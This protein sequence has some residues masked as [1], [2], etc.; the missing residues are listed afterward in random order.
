M[1]YWYDRI[2]REARDNA[3][4]SLTWNGRKLRLV[5]GIYRA[6]TLAETPRQAQTRDAFAY[7]WNRRATY[8]SPRMGELGRQWLVAKYLD[9]DPQNL[10]RLVPRGAR[11]LDAGSGAGF[12][13]LNFLAPRLADIHYLG[14]DISTAVDVAAARFREHGLPGEFLQ[15]DIMDLPF[16]P[17]S[18]DLIFSEGVL[19]HTNDTAAALSRLARLLVPDGVILFYVYKVK[20][21]V[22]EFCDDHVRSWI[23]DLDHEAAWDAL[24]PL[25]RLGAALGALDVTIDVPEDVPMLGI[26]A[27]PV[28]VQRLFY[29]YVC[30]CF[31]DP[32]LTL[33][34]MNH[35]NFDWYRPAN[36]TRHTPEEVERFCAD[37]GLAIDRMV[38]DGSGI[39]VIARRLCRALSE[40]VS[41]L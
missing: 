36:C 34:E 9:G 26:P 40:Q 29:Y 15:F 16:A 25:T 19:H 14:A 31:Y 5:D 33:D 27:G 12:S 7:K 38:V 17:K 21:P 2:A 6:E 30:K 28:S 1:S 3:D 4:G 24:M 41:A 35:A 18:F 11:L 39:S 37:A 20:A 22:R 13:A 8:E 10:E 32:E 23:K